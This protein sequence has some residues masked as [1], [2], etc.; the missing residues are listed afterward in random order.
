MCRKISYDMK[1]GNYLANNG[2]KRGSAL[3][4]DGKLKNLLK[5]T[6]L[7]RWIGTFDHSGNQTEAHLNNE[8][9]FSGGKSNYS[10]D[11]TRS[12]KA[13]FTLDAFS[14]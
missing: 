9:N 3:E 8:G 5:K 10:M 4:R 11:F 2:E 13:L 14:I 1:P 7:R 6:Y 12:R